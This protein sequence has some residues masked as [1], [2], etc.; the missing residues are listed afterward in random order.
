MVE[1]SKE[2]AW[3]PTDHTTLPL[4]N[5]SPPV[6]V[7]HLRSWIGSYKQLSAC[8]KDYTVPLTRLEKLTGSDKSSSLKISWT[9]DLLQD[10]NTAKNLIKNLEK[11]NTPTPDDELHTYSDF[12]AESAAVGGKLIIV[13]M[14]GNKKVKLNGGFF[15]PD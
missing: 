5:A 10:F 11:I 13:R 8:I 9:E 4:I 2:N 1:E 3:S 6:T 7:K 15:R 14:Q 12:S